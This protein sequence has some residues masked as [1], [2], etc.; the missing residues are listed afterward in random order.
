MHALKHPATIIRTATRA[1]APVILALIRELAD[2][3]KLSHEVTASVEA[4]EATLFGPISYAEVL[5]AEEEGEAAAFCLFFHNYSTFLAKP[6]VY[7]EDVFVRP[8]F[9]GRDLGKKLFAEIAAIARE[10]GC[11]RI[12]WWVLDW[13]E[14]AL[15]FYRTMGAEPMNEWT[16][17]RLTKEQ[18]EKM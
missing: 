15:K 17:Y 12:E 6:G 1:D 10:R 11:G 9:R 16:V 4:L 8:A 13:N 18:F 5:I 2:F 3:E 14:S 7:I